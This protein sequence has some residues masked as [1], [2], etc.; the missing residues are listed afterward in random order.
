MI[1]NGEDQAC[2]TAQQLLLAGVQLTLE[3]FLWGAA[4]P[5]AISTPARPRVRTATVAGRPIGCD[6]SVTEHEGQVAVI[7][8]QVRVMVPQLLVVLKTHSE[9]NQKVGD[10][11]HTDEG[12]TEWVYVVWTDWH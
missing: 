7:T 3:R 11:E 10:G 12:H 5:F 4:A 6:G 1:L 2:A 9:W 8:D